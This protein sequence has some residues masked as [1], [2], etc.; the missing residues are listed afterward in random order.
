MSKKKHKVA[1]VGEIPAGSTKIINI[2]KRS[3][4]V[5]NVDGAYHALPNLCPH[6]IGPLCEGSVSGTTDAS[7]ESGWKVE[8]VHDGEIVA[9]P[10]HGIEYHIPTGKCL[11]FP[12][13]SVRTY[14][15]WENEGAV[16]I[17][18]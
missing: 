5:F 10:W 9:C 16:W 14:N 17:E 18:L 1:A 2:G 8:W 7:K 11:A 4:G 6:Q 13:I 15:V 3:I 12:E